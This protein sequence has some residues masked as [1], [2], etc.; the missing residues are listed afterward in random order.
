MYSR[1]DRVLSTQ[2][3][4]GLMETY[5]DCLVRGL[6]EANH[7]LIGLG[8]RYPDVREQIMEWAMD[9]CGRLQYAPQV[10]NEKKTPQEAV[11]TYWASFSY[12]AR[13]IA[14]ETLGFVKHKLGWVFTRLVGSSEHEEA[15]PRTDNTV[16][17]QDT[18]TDEPVPERVLPPIPFGFALQ[19][20]PGQPCRLFYPNNSN[21][22]SSQPS[23]SPEFIDK[24]QKRSVKLLLFDFTLDLFGGIID[25]ACRAVVNFEIFF[26]SLT[27]LLF[28][29][30]MVAKT[31]SSCARPNEEERYLIR[32][33]ML[34]HM[35]AAA[36]FIMG[37]YPGFFPSIEAASI[38]SFFMTVIGLNMVW[39]L[40]VPES[41]VETVFNIYRSLRDLYTVAG[42]SNIVHEEHASPTTE[43]GDEKQ[44]VQNDDS[45]IESSPSDDEET[46][47]SSSACLPTKP[48]HHL[49]NPATSVQQDIR[50]TREI[51]R[52]ERLQQAADSPTDTHTGFDTDSES[53]SDDDAFVHI[54]RDTDD[55]LPA[56][57]MN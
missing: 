52:Q 29:N 11:L 45:D 14:K 6:K 53:E 32:S 57:L 46:L 7:E 13:K 31:G 26:V 22:Q 55:D 48:H 9:N 19:C 38:F 3:N 17:E 54:A 47:D 34:E 4:R 43:D 15:S 42:D 8:F 2:L 20:Q 39:K 36:L 23:I 10:V 21:M 18:H 12:R 30:S 40:F 49:A 25:K 56:W 41:Q 37:K 51:I 24:L 33:M 27:T 35:T 1:L 28:V 5:E 50:R 16:T 44:G